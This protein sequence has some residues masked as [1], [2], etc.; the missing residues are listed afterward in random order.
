M[1]IIAQCN[2]QCFANDDCDD[3]F[4]PH[5]QRNQQVKSR[6]NEAKNFNLTWL[7]NKRIKYLRLLFCNYLNLLQSPRS[8]LKMLALASDKVSGD[9]SCPLPNRWL[10]CF[11][12]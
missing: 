4:R 12:N 7:A 8:Y 9:V 2:K 1:K 5:S 10:L 6:I 11:G 3:N